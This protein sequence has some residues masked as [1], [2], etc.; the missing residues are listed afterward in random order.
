MNAMHLRGAPALA[1]C[2]MV[3]CSAAGCRST[4]QVA[5]SPPAQPATEPAAAWVAP[6]GREVLRVRARGF[7]IYT[8]ETGED[9]QMKWTL[10]G[11]KAE[12]RDESGR[13]VGKHYKGEA[14]PI[15]ES[16]DGSKVVG[17]KRAQR[18][19]P[20]PDSIPELQLDAKAAPG[21]PAGVLSGVTFVE[22]LDTS[23]G[24]P[25]AAT[26]STAI[27]EEARSPYTAEY[28]FYGPRE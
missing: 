26:P 16:S 15:W 18:K 7:Q 8:A 4:E 6:P 5:A 10:A 22:M 1:A 19:S 17:K 28:V 12:L 24:L 21:G 9:G 25:P 27:G 13:V 20:H 11:L 23:G 3:V 14:G 2:L